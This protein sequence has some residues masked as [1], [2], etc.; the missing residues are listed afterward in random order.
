MQITE[1]SVI[2]VR[3]AVVTFRS[4]HTALRFTLFPMLHLGRAGFYRR[5]T[6]MIGAC[7]L[8]VA[9]GY[10]GPSS[11]G[12][13]Y[14]TAMRWT[15]QRASQGLV[16]QNIDYAALDVPVIWPDRL[17]RRTAHA[18]R[19]PWHGWLDLLLLVPALVVTMAVGG[20]QRLMARSFEVDDT[21]DA[22]PFLG[23]LKKPMLTDRDAELV[24]ALTELHQTRAAEA[25]EV[26]VVYGAAHLPAAC[27]GL[28]D[29][30]YRPQR[31]AEWLSVIDY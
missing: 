4:P 27:R 24:A 28:A 20:R 12:L 19:M 30:G 11:V 1:V 22:R 17:T 31:G 21:T 14:L 29:L 23:F 13:A 10:D 9:E 3:S 15:R 18:R 2:G 5:V 16:H 6:T 7:D 8:I 25:I 26:A